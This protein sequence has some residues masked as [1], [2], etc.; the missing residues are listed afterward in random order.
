ML[1]GSR[2]G[3]VTLMMVALVVTRG[4]H[5]QLGFL[6]QLET[7]WLF[8]HF[9]FK[10]KKLASFFPKKNLSQKSWLA[11]FDKKIKPKKLAS[12]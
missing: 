4:R 2:E 10:P 11:F 12:F 3:V 5:S 6:S 8:D 7:H 9:N 1:I